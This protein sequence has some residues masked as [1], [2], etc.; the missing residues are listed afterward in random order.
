METPYNE[1]AL[2]HR[3]LELECWIHT[4]NSQLPLEMKSSA[5]AFPGNAKR[6]YML[7]SN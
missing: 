3:V 1:D 4:E 6:S 5:T 2:S 7:G